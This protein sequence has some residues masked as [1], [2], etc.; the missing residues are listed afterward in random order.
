MQGASHYFE[1]ARIVGQRKLLFGEPRG[2]CQFV[3]HLLDAFGMQHVSRTLGSL[4]EGHGSSPGIVPLLV[5]LRRF[6]V[7]RRYIQRATCIAHFV[8]HCLEGHGSSP[9]T[10]P[11]LVSLRRF[12]V[13]VEVRFSKS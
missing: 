12:F 11:L 2:E 1:P 8:A 6:F 10:M 9:G 7:Q 13:P 4:L 3:Y 5:S